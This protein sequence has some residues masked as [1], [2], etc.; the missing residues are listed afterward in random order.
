MSTTTLMAEVIVIGAFALIWVALFVF[1][2]FG[3]DLATVS[4]WFSQYKDWSTAVTLIAVVVSYQLGWSI[5]QLSYF[6]ARKTFNKIIKSRIFK[7]QWQN[8]DAIK[9][10][11]FMRGSSFMLDKIRE[12]L[13]VVRLTRSVCL[14]FLL[15]SV[16]LF[17]LGNWY[18]GLVTLGA[19]VLFF[20]QACD[21]YAIYCRHI[22]N[23]YA[24][25]TQDSQNA[26]NEKNRKKPTSNGIH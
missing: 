20:I 11:V 1:K 3:L 5:N 17:I 19:T 21:I 23:A 6:I 12:R 24:I 9:T 18:L 25:I 16:G 8:Y 13:N 7:T 2:L 15:I 26:A 10:A 22:L 14:N 4:S